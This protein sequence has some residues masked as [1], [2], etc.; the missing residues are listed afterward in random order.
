[1]RLIFSCGSGVCQWRV[2]RICCD[3][4]WCH[5][6]VQVAQL[7]GGLCERG[8]LD[9]QRIQLCVPQYE[10]WY[11]MCLNKNNSCVPEKGTKSGLKSHKFTPIICTKPVNFWLFRNTLTSCFIFIWQTQ[12]CILSAVGQT[13]ASD[14]SP[15]Y[16]MVG[17]DAIFKCKLPSFVA[18]FV[19]VVSWIDSE[20]NS[21]FPSLSSGMTCVEIFS[22]YYC[23]Q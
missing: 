8:Q 6:K 20:S 15:E 19:S 7:C 23:K 11:D 13:Y 2:P 16:T 18:D 9:W 12:I 10:P 3:G 1:M 21:V 14:V 4:Q 17:N 5:L 22:A